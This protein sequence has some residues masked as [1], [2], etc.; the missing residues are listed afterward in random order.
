MN[1][2]H[3]NHQPTDRLNYGE[4]LSRAFRQVVADALHQVAAHGLPGDHHL[5]IAFQSDHPGVDMPEWLRQQ[6]PQTMSI[7]LQYEFYDLDVRAEGFSVKLSFDNRF[8]TLNIPFEAIELFADPAAQFGLRLKG[9][10]SPAPEDQ[11]QSEEPAGTE[12]TDDT[13]DDN[14]KVISLDAFRQQPRPS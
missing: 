4:F 13:A 8:A 10:P 11:E 2:N 9:A 6:H 12:L 1:T 3:E 7:I 14:P 5:Y